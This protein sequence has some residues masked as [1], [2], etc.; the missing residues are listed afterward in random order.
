MEAARRICAPDGATLGYRLWQP[1]AP[2]RLMILIHGLA[3]NLSRW[4]DFAA[5]TRLR[6]TWDILRLDLRGHAGSL[7]RG[8]IG[9]DEWCADLATIL[10]AEAMP[11]ALLVGHCLGANVALHFA[12]RHPEATTGLVLIEPMFRGALGPAMRRVAAL[13]PLIAP[14]VPAV[15]ALNALGV[16]R[17]HIAPLDLER[18]DREARAEI[19]ATGAF[20]EERYAAPLEDLRTTAT[21]TYLQD[22]LAVTAPLP[23]LSRIRAPVLALLSRGGTF[24]DPATTERLLAPLRAYELV[25]LEARHWIPTERP[26]EMRDAIDRWSARFDAEEPARV[27]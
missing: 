15:R 20:P 5:T 17:R 9:M 23:D 7:Y 19:A 2:R 24:S 8:R 16:H 3:S 10:R 27:T 22:L 13:R 26:D 18:L 1:G 12:D 11:R 6:A 21:A 14:V 4:W 25:R